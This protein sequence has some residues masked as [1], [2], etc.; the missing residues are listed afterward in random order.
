MSWRLHKTEVAKN[1]IGNIENNSDL[2]EL[3][4]FLVKLCTWSW[5][6]PELASLLAM[7]ETGSSDIVLRGLPGRGQTWRRITLS[8]FSKLNTRLSGP[9]SCL[10]LL[11]SPALVRWE[12]GGIPWDGDR[13]TVVS[14]SKAPTKMSGMFP[15]SSENV[16]VGKAVHLSV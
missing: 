9:R 7:S 3:K 6:E 10:L 15:S 4:C 16:K 14:P 8:R 1:K 5:K 2:Q 12:E 13:R 11:A